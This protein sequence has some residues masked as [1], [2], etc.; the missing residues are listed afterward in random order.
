MLYLATARYWIKF[1]HAAWMIDSLLGPSESSI[2]KLAK[3][4]IVLPANAADA[5]SEM[6]SNKAT[7]KRTDRGRWA[8]SRCL[9]TELGSSPP[10]TGA[11]ARRKLITDAPT[12]GRGFC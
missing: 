3:R 10:R 12:L 5:A 11:N 7:G 9:L 6:H 1:V 4:L 2:V 8:G